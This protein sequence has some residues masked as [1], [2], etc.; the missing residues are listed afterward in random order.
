MLERLLLNM[1]RAGLVVASRGRSGGYQLKISPQ[2]LYL[3]AILSAVGGWRQV[4]VINDISANQP[5]AAAIAGDHLELQLQQRLLR[6]MQKELAALSLA[7]LV[8]DQRSLEAALNPE[9]GLMLG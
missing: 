9:G 6:A 7:E 1:R 2:E 5:S 4:A 3:E 8:Y